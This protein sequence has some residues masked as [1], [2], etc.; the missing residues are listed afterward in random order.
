MDRLQGLLQRVSVQARMFH[1]GPLCG[2][3]DFAPNGQGQLH[4]VRRGPVEVR[5][6]G[7]CLHVTAPSLLFYPRPLAHRFLTDADVGADMACANIVF[8]PGDGGPIAHALPAFLALPLDQLR[9]CAAV[10]EVLFDEAFAQR[11][12]RH[13]VVDRLFEVV[14]VLLLRHLLDHG[15]VREGP[16][17]G[18]AHPQLARALVALHDAPSADWTLDKLAA[19]ACMSRS[20]FAEV[21][22]QVVGTPPGSYLAQYRITLAK[23]AV[24]RGD[25]LERIARDVGYGSATALSRAF[26][27]VCG[28]S[29][30]TWRNAQ[31]PSSGGDG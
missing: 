11:C 10:L 17:A 1:S 3:T 27:G 6:D 16:L 21:F 30:R 12:G 13:A 23:T 2:F 4:L 20:R 24:L 14:L 29:P 18:L 28:V 31:A 5:H 7:G 8:G 19:L 26:A 25:P 22:A 15:H 9:G